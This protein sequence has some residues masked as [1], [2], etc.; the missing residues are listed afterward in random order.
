[1]A[2]DESFLIACVAGH[3]ENLG[4]ADYWI[5]VRDPQGQW[6]PARNLG[7]RFNG[8]DTRAAS[9]FLSPDG[10]YLFFSSS[11]STVAWP[12]RFNRADLHRFHGQPGN[13]ASDIWWVD[14]CVLAPYLEGGA[15]KKIK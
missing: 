14:A 10:Q 7:S 1:V 5:S 13:G 9:A 2:P 8:P 4:A 15:G 11:R 12:D 6:Q 3:A